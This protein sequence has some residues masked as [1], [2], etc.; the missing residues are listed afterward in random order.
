VDLRER[1]HRAIAD[2]QTHEDAVLVIEEAMLLYFER[3]LAHLKEKGAAIHP[4]TAMSY[5]KLLEN[6]LVKTRSL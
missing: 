2:T 1:V 3:T 6:T 4:Q 5:Q